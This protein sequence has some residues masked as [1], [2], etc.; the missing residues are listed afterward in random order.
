MPDTHDMVLHYDQMRSFYLG[1]SAGRFYPR[2]E[3]DTNFGFGAPTPCFYPPGI[4]YLTSAFYWITQDWLH[5]VITVHLLMMI[6]SG[7]AIYFYARRWLARSAASV[8]MALYIIWPYHLLDQYIRGAMAELLSFIWMPLMLLLGELLV[9]NSLEVKGFSGVT[10]SVQ[11]ATPVFSKRRHTMMRAL[12][13]MTGLAMCYGAFLWSHPPT[14]YQFTL[15]FSLFILLR[16]LAS[17]DWQGLIRVGA[18]MVIGLALAAAY[19]Y[20]AFIE[21]KF[22]RHEILEEIWPYHHTYVFAPFGYIQDNPSFYRLINQIWLCGTVM[23][24][25]GGVAL[26]LFGPGRKA[27]TAKVRNHA[28][29]WLILGCSASFMMTSVSAPFGRFLPKIEIGV[30]SWRMLSITTLII[31]LLAGVITHAVIEFRQERRKRKVVLL[32]LVAGSIIIGSLSFSALRVVAPVNHSLPFQPELGHQNE[33]ML[34]VTAPDD[35]EDLPRM[36]RAL[37]TAGNG[38]ISIEE[39]K[40]EHRALRAKLTRPDQLQVRTFNYPGWTAR[41]D[42]RPAPLHSHKELGNI[43]LDLSAGNH[44]VSLDFLETPV[45]RTGDRITVFSFLLTMAILGIC[46]AGIFRKAR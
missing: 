12:L 18:S 32:S 24:V 33:A 38:E 43:I 39:W 6:S 15:A 42:G 34:P 25:F 16:G 9:G 13:R 44:H 7:I 21:Q 1:L 19:L 31:A 5:T 26:C 35:P 20:P 45:R 28:V 23:I 30:F 3:E 8:V 27:S 11:N 22:I 17:K 2:W 14:A 37:L 36:E 40:P 10:P 41:V 4:Y 29:L 46:L